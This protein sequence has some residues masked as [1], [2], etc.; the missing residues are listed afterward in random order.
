MIVE[1]AVIVKDELGLLDS[2]EGS[3]DFV[4]GG[5]GEV[6]GNEVACG[7][8]ETPFEDVDG[9]A[10][11]GVEVGGFGEAFGEADDGGEVAVGLIVME[12]TLLEAGRDTG[13][14][15]G[16]PGNFGLVD[17]EGKVALGGEEGDEE[18]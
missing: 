14:F 13:E 7:G 16:G 11:L 10:A 6:A 2:G 15:D 12:D 1:R 3:V 4:N 5:V 17:S 18:G 8:F 9:M